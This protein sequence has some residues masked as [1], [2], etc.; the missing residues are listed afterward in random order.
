MITTHT[1]DCIHSRYSQRNDC[2]PAPHI[3]VWNT[4]QSWYADAARF[5]A[6]EDTP[7]CRIH[8]YAWQLQ[9]ADE[10]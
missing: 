2:A 8:E 7:Y 9:S 1:D 5:E 10:E 4:P 3:G 6:D